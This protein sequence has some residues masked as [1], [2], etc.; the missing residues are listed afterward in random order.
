MTVIVD[1]QPR[2]KEVC[3]V[4]ENLVEKDYNVVIWPQSLK[5]KDIND[6][7]KAG[8]SLAYVQSLID[9]NTFRGLQARANFY[10]WKRC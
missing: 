6:I 4:I 2:N 8:K 1:N 3:K 9:K 10:A 5:E 7:V